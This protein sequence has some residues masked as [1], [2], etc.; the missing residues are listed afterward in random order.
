MQSLRVHTVH[1]RYVGRVFDVRTRWTPGSSEPLV[2]QALLV[3]RAGWMQRV[4]L[5]PWRLQELPW[6]AVRSSRDGVLF[7]E[8]TQG[9]T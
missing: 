3:G 9:G 2:V 5:R 4:G 7:V 1:G 8:E 6:S